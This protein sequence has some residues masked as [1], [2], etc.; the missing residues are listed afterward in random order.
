MKLGL[1]CS[2]LVLLGMV[3]CAS[4]SSN[5]TGTDVAS[6]RS[7]PSGVATIQFLDLV[8]LRP[9]ML[10][11]AT[12]LPTGITIAS[13]S[14]VGQA[15]GYSQAP[16][17]TTYQFTHFP[18]AGGGTMDG[19]VSVSAL[20]TGPSTTTYTET[21]ALVVT[22]SGSTPPTWTY[23]GT[24]VVSLTGTLGTFSLQSP[25]AP[26]TMA[27]AD[28]ADASKN[29]TYTYA[30]NAA[31]PL[32]TMAWDGSAVTLSGGFV[33]KQTLPAAAAKTVTCT[34]DPSVKWVQGSTCN[35]PTQGTFNLALASS[36][37]TAT[38][39]FGPDC[40]TASINGAT[41]PLGGN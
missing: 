30:P 40:G 33:V 39:T 17:L 27:Y 8:T 15:T 23:T 35:Y 4:G 3:G 2:T 9:D 36:A 32:L 7:S 41:F 20:A 16:T 18:T 25:D 11:S 12:S 34:I 1:S 26:I 19:T 29:K 6:I 14:V 37:A 38:V 5:V 28:P 13:G 24:Q 21:L 22:L 10:A 31:L